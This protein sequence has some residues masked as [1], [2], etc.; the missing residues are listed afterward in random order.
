MG[1]A[2]YVV[3]N[4]IV[5]VEFSETDFAIDRCQK[6]LKQVGPWFIMVLHSTTYKFRLV[7]RPYF[8]RPVFQLQAQ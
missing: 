1:R 4:C 2:T 6:Y 3:T 8:Y 5:R 7:I